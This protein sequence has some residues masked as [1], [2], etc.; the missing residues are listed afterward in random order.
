MID[1][2][3]AR[4]FDARRG[5]L[6]EHFA[7]DWSAHPDAA[8]ADVV[9]PGHHFEWVWLLREYEQLVGHRARRAGATALYDFALTH[10]VSEDGLVHDELGERR[11]GAQELA[12]R[13]AAH[14]GDQGGGG[15]PR[16][17]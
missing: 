9:E 15:A 8:L 3:E 13:V 2:F 11:L 10:G 14:R 4:L 16:R 12:S 6:L 17:R 5:V 1:L 7:E